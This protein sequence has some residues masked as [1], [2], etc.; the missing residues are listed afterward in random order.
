MELLPSE[1]PELKICTAY[2]VDGTP[3]DKFPASMRQLVRCEPIYEELPG[4]QEPTSHVRRFD[5]LP[6]H[7]REYVKRLEHLI[8]CPVALVSVGPE[9]EQAII[10]QP[11]L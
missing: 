10:V 11:I 1:L 2:E 4:W 8:G 3:V 5:D 7:A 9:R 6:R